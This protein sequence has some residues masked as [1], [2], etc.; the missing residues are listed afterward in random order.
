MN[1][2]TSVSLLAAMVLGSSFLAEGA[3]TI[4]Q[5]QPA[6][7][8]VTSLTN[9][10]VVFSEQVEGISIFDFLVNGQAADA[11][12][13][14]DETYTFYFRQPTHGTVLISWDLNHTIVDLAGNRFDA[15]GAGATWQYNFVDNAAP[16]VTVLTPAASLTVRQLT[17][18]EVQ[19]NEAVSGID[20]GDLLINGAPAGTITVLGEGR[21]RFGFSEPAPG[22]V[23]VAWAANHQIR[24]FANP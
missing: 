11:I 14:A 4:V 17:Q 8:T 16:V 7:G 6:P 15:N 5:K 23:Q 1:A 9:V 13:G 18:V 19:F 22:T 20:A 3:P 21:Y 10:T 2:Q 12:S 24:D